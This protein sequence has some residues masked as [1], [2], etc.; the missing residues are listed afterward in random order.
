MDK[1][2]LTKKTE[3]VKYEY[4]K[5]SNCGTGAKIVLV[6]GA[7]AWV[8]FTYI[9]T[10]WFLTY[11]NSLRKNN[12]DAILATQVNANA[13]LGTGIAYIVF[14]VAVVVTVLVLIFKKYNLNGVKCTSSGVFKIT[15]II[16]GVIMIY[17]SIYVLLG[18]LWFV[19][20]LRD[21][22]DAPAGTGVFIE[23]IG[24]AHV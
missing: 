6:I 5:V 12:F 18:L 19:P 21:A 20:L 13:L 9:I 1:Q 8:L 23:Q 3:E 14:S 11:G 2:T 24:R 4:T 17:A 16:F 10:L 22:A 15:F 7:L